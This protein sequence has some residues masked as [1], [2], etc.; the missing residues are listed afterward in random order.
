MRARLHAGGWPR[1]PLNKASSPAPMEFIHGADPDGMRDSVLHGQSFKDR[2]SWTTPP[3]VPMP[4]LFPGPRDPS[5]THDPWVGVRGWEGGGGPASASLGGA[6]GQPLLVPLPGHLSLWEVGCPGCATLE[7]P[8]SSCASPSPLSLHHSSCKHLVVAI[9]RSSFDA[10][11]SAVAPRVVRFTR[12]LSCTAAASH[13]SHLLRNGTRIA[14]ST[15]QAAKEEARSEDA[16]V[17][18]A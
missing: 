11:M 10:N 15:R 9:I 3:P 14:A 18:P 17:R 8:L 16:D 1:S 4:V 13:P 12:A 7:A 5:P 6:P 2:E